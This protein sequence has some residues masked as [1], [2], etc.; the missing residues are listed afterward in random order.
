MNTSCLQYIG[1][2]QTAISSYLCIITD[3]DIDIR[4]KRFVFTVFKLVT[5][6]PQDECLLKI[7]TDSSLLK[8]N[9]AFRNSLSLLLD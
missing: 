6:S 2:K 7:S 5:L 9:G 3:I 8:N 1:E 4:V